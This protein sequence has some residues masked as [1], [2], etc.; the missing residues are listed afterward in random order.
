[1]KTQIL[2]NDHNSASFFISAG[3][4]V[5]L[6]A[7]LSVA[8]APDSYAQDFPV[9]VAPKVGPPVAPAISIPG[10][11]SGSAAPAPATLSVLKAAAIPGAMSSI[12]RNASMG[13]TLH[14]TLGHSIFIDTKTRLRRV[15]VSDPAVINSVTLSPNQIIVTGMSPGISSLTLLDEAGL[16]QSYVISSDLDID[17]LRAA[18]T[19]AMRSDA[20]K[21]DGSGGRVTLSG[22]VGSDAMAD[23]A[24]KLA[25]LY[26][27]EVANALVVVPSHPKQVRLQVRILEV[28]R[29]KALQLGINLF[30]PGGNS[31]YIA[32]STSSQFPTAATLAQS[33]AAGAI[34]TLATTN[35]LSFLL[36]SAKLNLGTTIQDLQ[37]KQVLQ[38]LAEPT[39]TTISGQKADF[40]SGGEFPFPVVQPGSGAGSAPVI[41]I[42]FRP[43]GVKVEFTPV[44]N[45]DG[46]IRLKVAPEV[47][48]LDYGNAVSVS[49]ITIPALSTRRATTEVEL[50]SEQSF[51]IS[52]LLDQRTTDI[53]TKNPGAANIPILGNLFKSKNANHSTTELV[54]VVTPTVVDPLSET[55][56][57]NQPDM[58]VPTLDIPKFDKSL[59]KDRNPSPAAPALTPDHPPTVPPVFPYMTPAATPAAGAAGNSGQT[60]A[61][62][63]APAPVTNAPTQS[64][65]A[66]SPGAVSASTIDPA[67]LPFVNSDSKDQGADKPAV[68]SNPKE[69][70]AD[71][72]GST[73]MVEVMALSHDSDADVMVAALKRR[74]YDVAINH[75]PQDS[76]L[77]LDV[78][79]FV[80]K[81]DAE[82]MRQRLLRDGYNAT[83][84]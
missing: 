64:N 58:P 51:A 67:L 8:T 75:V 6:A 30:S 1:V 13:Q 71:T 20:V 41:S 28:D 52:G 68:V 82:N 49:G 84:K 61:Q 66:T 32:S 7:I 72:V 17:G 80:N 54:V 44:V 55:A 56:T 9:T 21:I 79:P 50:R 76:L 60:P 38:I 78:G 24:G 31:S 73:S 18:M 65:S 77:H 35:P 12:S 59:G 10:E 48:A 4:T 15:Y 46:T 42:Q 3:L 39:I 45:E 16:A 70:R 43:F 26:S 74:G 62:Q 36:Y 23:A 14:V 81:R 2:K 29:S 22:V 57:P 37:S 19:A 40:L 5:G 83:L 11:S 33:A 27:K 63:V 53:L 34:G 69:R 25:A 47:S